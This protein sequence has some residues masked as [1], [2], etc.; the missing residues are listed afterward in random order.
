[1][2]NIVKNIYD[3]YIRNSKWLFFVLMLIAIPLL[4]YVNSDEYKNSCP[5]AKNMQQTKT[6]T[7]QVSNSFDNSEKSDVDKINR[8]NEKDNF[9]Y[10]SNNFSTDNE[11][12]RDSDKRTTDALNNINEKGQS[13][14]SSESGKSSFELFK[15]CINSSGW[16][17]Y[18]LKT[19][20]HCKNQKARFNNSL[21]PIVVIECSDNRDLCVQ[22]GITG[23]PAWKNV[24][25]N[26]TF[27]GD[28]PLSNLQAITGCK[29]S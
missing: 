9:A 8:N 28:Q 29:L 22:E 1:M 16:Q 6:Y 23:V 4:I 7:S 3:F 17:L 24:F 25:S 15:S 5:C 27:F 19:C 21:E 13:L 11:I 10:S 18:V 20:P 26:K 2:H 12:N 14:N